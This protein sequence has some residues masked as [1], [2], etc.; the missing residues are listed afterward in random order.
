MGLE[1]CVHMY[2]RS[3]KRSFQNACMIGKMRSLNGVE[4]AEGLGIAF[5]LAAS[6]AVLWQAF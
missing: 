5:C 1:S 4:A 6:C 2:T 3:H